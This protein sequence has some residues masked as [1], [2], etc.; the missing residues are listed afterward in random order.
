MGFYYISLF[1]WMIFAVYFAIA[2]AIIITICKKNKLSTYWKAGLLTVAFIAPCAE[3]LLIAYNFG[4]LCRK[5]AG[6]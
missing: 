2:A 4:Q 3:E 1:S 6:T 5:D